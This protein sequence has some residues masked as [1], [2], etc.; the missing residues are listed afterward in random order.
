MKRLARTACNKLKKLGAPVYHE[1]GNFNG[2]HF[3]IGGEL[4]DSGDV[5]YADYYQEDLRERH[6]KPGEDGVT[7][8]SYKGGTYIVVNPFGIRTDVYKILDEHGLS[9]E[10]ND[11]GTLT[12]WDK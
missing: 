2:A 3:V 7:F 4:R 1:D 6:A 11:P 8:K 10:W 5:Y 12:I 9:A